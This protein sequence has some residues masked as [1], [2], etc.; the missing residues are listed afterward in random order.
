MAAATI[1]ITGSLRSDKRAQNSR[2][3]GLCFLA[4]FDRLEVL[5]EG[6]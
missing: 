3:M 2:M 6:C 5:T 1:A 4:T